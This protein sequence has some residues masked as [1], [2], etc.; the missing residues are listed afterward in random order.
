MSTAANVDI[1]LDSNPPFLTSELSDYVTSLK[2]EYFDSTGQQLQLIGFNRADIG[3][4]PGDGI[5]EAIGF[6]FVFSPFR[7]I[8][9]AT[10]TLSLRK[11]VS[12]N[13]DFLL[14]ADNLSV[15]MPESD[16]M[17]YGNDVLR[18]L[19]PSSPHE[20]SVDLTNTGTNPG[21]GGEFGSEDL[22]GLLLDGD[23]NVVYF[24]DAIIHSVRLQ[25]EVTLE[26]ALEKAIIDINPDIFAVIIMP[27]QEPEEPDGQFLG[28][29]IEL[30]EG[31]NGLNVSMV[32]LSMNGTKTE[33]ATAT[34]AVVDKNMLYAEFPLSLT[35]VGD[36]L[37]LPIT[38]ISV[39]GEKIEVRASSPPEVSIDCIE[40]TVLGE[41]S[42]Q[43]GSFTGTD[44]L[45]MVLEE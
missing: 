28:A 31:L 12:E 26:P 9:S 37:G 2:E 10:L 24:D 13:T 21:F 27:N 32:T 14:F 40:L 34:P 39:E 41:F 33:L 7:S 43:M 17:F 20:V 4:G 16:R 35:N 6:S 8:E 45:R 18:S 11:V 29:Y 44:A 25:I 5:D 36:I 15:Y 3:D 38:E 22:T 19:S 30:P 42:D 23:L 1:T